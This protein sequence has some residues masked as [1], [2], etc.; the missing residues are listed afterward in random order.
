AVCRTT[1]SISDRPPVLKSRL[2]RSIQSRTTAVVLADR[3]VTKR[4]DMFGVCGIKFVG[5]RTE[6]REHDGDEWIACWGNLKEC[7]RRGSREHGYVTGAG[8]RDNASMAAFSIDRIERDLSTGLFMLGETWVRRI[9]IRS[10]RKLTPK[11][12]SAI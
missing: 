7:E 11:T 8:F 9:H 4:E 12:P 5:S 2:R 6:S 3:H 10:A 1:E